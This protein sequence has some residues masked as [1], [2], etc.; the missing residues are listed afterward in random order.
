MANEETYS[1]WKSKIDAEIKNL[2]WERAA[3]ALCS[4]V[5]TET[6]R[7]LGSGWL[8]RKL[9]EPSSGGSNG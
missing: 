4:G 2:N 7:K 3:H 8:E 9:R 1:E 6:M 5:D